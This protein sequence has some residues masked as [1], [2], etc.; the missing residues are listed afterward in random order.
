MRGSQD[1]VL[2]IGRIC[3]ALIFIVSGF[4]KMFTMPAFAAMMA[5]KGMPLAEITPILAVIIELGGGLVLAIGLETRL[6]ATLFAM[7]VVA[8]TLI[9]HSFWTMDDP[10]LRAAN[11]VH[12]YK[13]IAII[14]GFLLLTATGGGLYSLDGRGIRLW[15]RTR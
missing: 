2:A 13:N 7:Y 4:N 9:S 1:A 15:K 3:L 6:M 5:R 8:A 10:A 14:G 12:F 11:A